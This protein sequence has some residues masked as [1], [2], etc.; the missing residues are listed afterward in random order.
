MSSGV[1]LAEYGGWVADERTASTSRSRVVVPYPGRRMREV[2]ADAPAGFEVD[3]RFEPQ[4]NFTAIEVE[5]F[6][7]WYEPTRAFFPTQWIAMTNPYWLDVLELPLMYRDGQTHHMISPVDGC[8]MEIVAAPYG[9]ITVRRNGV[10]VVVSYESGGTGGYPQPERLPEVEPAT[11]AKP[12]RKEQCVDTRY[13]PRECPY[14]SELLSG[15]VSP[16]IGRTKWRRS[17]FDGVKC[18]VLLEDDGRVQVRRD[19]M[20]VEIVTPY[21]H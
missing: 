9:R 17:E 7:P 14:W 13:I 19:N 5:D 2:N 15:M 11:P 18:Q 8:T 16:D 4:Y 10:Q 12:R 20:Q 1:K 21:E 3:L 6:D